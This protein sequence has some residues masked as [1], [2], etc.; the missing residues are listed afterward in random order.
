MK[1]TLNMITQ[2]LVYVMIEIFL[3]Q[4][5][6]GRLGIKKR[7]APVAESVSQGLK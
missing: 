4:M 1:N 3:Q 2:Y 7:A 6:H 5:A